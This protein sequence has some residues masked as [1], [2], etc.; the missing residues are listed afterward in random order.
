MAEQPG[1]LRR[2]NWSE[3][4]PFTRIFNAFR[5]A[6]GPS[7]LALLLVALLLMGV[8]GGLL[9][10]IWPDS[11]KPLRQE[12]GAFARVTDI[13][14]WREQMH[15]ANAAALMTAYLEAGKPIPENLRKTFDDDREEAVDNTL[16]MIE[17]RYKTELNAIW[18]D[19]SI[20]EEDRP[21]AI[22]RLS[23]EYNA[24]YRHVQALAPYGIFAAW[25]RYDTEMVGQMIRAATHLNFMGGLD[26]VLQARGPAG[27]GMLA[28]DLDPHGIGVVGSL[29]LILRGK[30]WLITQH[31]FFALLLGVGW[32][33]ILAL[34]GGAVARMAA[35]TFARDERISPRAALA[36]AFRRF[37]GFFTAPLLPI[38]MI[39]A[40][41]LLLAIGGM[42][43]SVPY[44]GELL[45]GLGLLLGLVGG[46]VITLVLIGFLGGGSL[47]YPA[48]AV[49]GSD[50][51]DAMSRSYSYVYARPWR[52]IFYYLVALV[53]GSFCYVF[54]RFFVLLMFK[55][56]RGFMDLG[57]RA[58]ERPGTG[59]PEA[60]KIHAM[61]GFPTYDNLLGRVEPF[62]T[63]RWEWGASYLH[64]LW[65]L[66]AVLLLCAFLLS[67]YYCASTI[68]YF[69]LRREVDATDIEDV[70][71]EDEDEDLPGSAPA[72]TSGPATPPSSDPVAPPPAPQP[73]TGSGPDNTAF[74]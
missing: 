57:A 71:L 29:V 27:V 58:T 2:I 11:L 42:V 1:E 37:L 4:F 64:Y 46:F 50:S 35:L 63:Y 49:E 19:K 18:S 38:G 33:A 32:L 39:L 53:Y 22:A 52:T 5:M 45:S 24:R 20:K 13:D 3:L 36:F 55:A 7:K 8:W 31:P 28:T 60:T 21:A 9:D 26:D 44:I 40:V 14:T 68:I 54:L 17:E 74:A 10:A 23:R 72:G 65:L 66:L 34:F 15:E 56:T 59:F 43:A 16:E 70:Y 30:Q 73:P 62:G 48:I 25:L 61:W 12:V 47:M 69:L 51:F 67:F 6:I 41:G